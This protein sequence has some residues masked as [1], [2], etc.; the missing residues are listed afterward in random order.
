[1]TVSPFPLLRKAEN[2]TASLHILLAREVA[3][4]AS[5]EI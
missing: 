5:I 3:L 4:I 1:M 2:Q